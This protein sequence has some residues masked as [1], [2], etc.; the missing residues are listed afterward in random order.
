MTGG[1]TPVLPI[2]H[3]VVVEVTHL[4]KSTHFFLISDLF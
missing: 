1:E 2:R 3:R 4:G